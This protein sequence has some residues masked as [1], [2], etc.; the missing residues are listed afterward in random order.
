MLVVVILSTY[1]IVWT[2]SK[3]FASIIYFEEKLARLGSKYTD[4]KVYRHAFIAMPILQIAFPIYILVYYRVRKKLISQYYMQDRE[5]T[6]I[7]L[8]GKVN[9]SYNQIIVYYASI[10]SMTIVLSIVKGVNAEMLR[11]IGFYTSMLL[12]TL[13]IKLYYKRT[14]FRQ[15][16]KVKYLAI[17]LLYAIAIYYVLKY[18]MFFW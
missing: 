5:E 3:T 11:F 1:V 17:V 15:L 10:L 9:K 6:H 16:R 7:E 2:H 14:F 8:V 4:K 13:Y 18:K 12:I